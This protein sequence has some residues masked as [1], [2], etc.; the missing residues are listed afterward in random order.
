VPSFYACQL[1]ITSNTKSPIVIENQEIGRVFFL[2]C[3]QFLSPL[4]HPIELSYR[5]RTDKILN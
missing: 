3:P 1:N 5:F 2:P 4:Q